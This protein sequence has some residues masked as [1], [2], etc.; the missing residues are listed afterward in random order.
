[1]T[2]ISSTNNTTTNINDPRPQANTS[3]R[4][5][6][7][8]YIHISRLASSPLWTNLGITSFSQQNYLYLRSQQCGNVTSPAPPAPV[9]R[10]RSRSHGH[11]D[12]GADT[13]AV[14]SGVR[15]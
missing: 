7:D 1:M 9:P 4:H 8:T 6:L 10:V 2:A 3:S 5:A 15:V 11:A 14:M 13:Y 12:R